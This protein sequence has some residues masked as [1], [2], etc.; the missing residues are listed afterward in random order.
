VVVHLPPKE[1]AALRL[2]L[3]HAGQIVTPLQLR[4]ALWG[5][6]HVTAESVPKCISSLRARLEP[7]ECIQT[8]YKR[9]YRF[10]AEVRRQSATRT[11]TIPRL[12]IVPFETGFSVPEHLGSAIA[13]GTIARLTSAHP[14]S[15]AVLARDSVFTLALRG[16]TAQQIGELLKADLVLA[17]TLRVLPSHFRLRVEMILVEDGAQIWVEDFLVARSRIAGL[18]LELI[19]R[20]VF[21]L[22]SGVHSDAPALTS[23]PAPISSPGLNAGGM[24]IS[25]AA[26]STVESES[27]PKQREAYDFFLRGHYEWQTLQRHRMQDGLQHLLRATELDPCLLPARVDL[28]NLCVTQAFYGFM[29]P[30]VEA[31]HVRRAAGSQAAASGP[32]IGESSPGFSDRAEAM[33]PALGWVK[34]HVDH[35]LAAAAQAFSL[36]AHLPHDPCV[37]RMRFMFALSR[38]RFAEAVDLLRAAIHLDPFSPWLHSRLA[39]AFHLEGRASES[40]EHIRH[41]LS[42]FPDH[43]GAC[44]YGSMILAFNGEAA[45]A[46]ELAEGLAQRSPYYDVATAVHA[47]ALASRGSRDEAS[48]ILERLQW[49][50]RERFVMSTFLPAVYVALGDLDAALAQLRASAVTRCPWFFQMLADPRLKPLQGLPAFGEMRAI[51]SRIEAAAA[52]QPEPEA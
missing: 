16:T 40:V 3:A 20:L 10:S 48:A 51:L 52:E 37:T 32:R 49:M 6:V 1:L 45:D 35:D 25:A 11:G 23:A 39:W 18:E 34:L 36:S 30:A 9:G 12:A 41:A 44:L 46:V 4:R 21:R 14:P 8:V 19:D 2:L 43:E 33:L 29:S 22:N 26:A 15:V 50:S 17:G 31:D 13:E 38:H 42:L 47:Y 27:D 7:D 5:D 24:A 28:A